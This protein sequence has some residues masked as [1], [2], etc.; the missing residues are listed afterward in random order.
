MLQ[1]FEKKLRTGK[2]SGKAIS[3][4]P[5]SGYCYGFKAKE[6]WEEEWELGGGQLGRLREDVLFK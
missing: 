5:Y 6:G 1:A 3:K 2:Y 4:I